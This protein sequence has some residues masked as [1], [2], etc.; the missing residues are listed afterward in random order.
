[1]KAYLKSKSE[2]PCI[3]IY[4]H[5]Y[6]PDVAS[7][8][9][10]LKEL[11]EGMISEFRIVV[12][13]V[14]PSYGGTVNDEYKKQK[15]YFEKINGVEVI[16]VR[17]PKFDKTKKISRIKNILAYFLRAMKVTGKIKN[18]EY[19]YSISQP[20]VLGG[21]LGVWG[22][23]RKRASFL[24]N[25]QD[26]NPEQIVATGY[27]KNKIILSLMMYFDKFSCQKAD[28]VIVVGRDM[29][30]TLR[31]RFTDK[32]GNISRKIPK[33][34]FIN[35]WVDEKEIYPLDLYNERVMEFRIKYGLENKFVIMY[36]GNIG[37]YYDLENLIKI[38]KDFRKGY[39]K[40]GKYE[41]GKK[42]RDGREVVFAFVGAGSIKDKL[43]DYAKSHRF[44]N[45]IFIPYQ[46]KENLI[47][48]LNAADVH[49]CVSAEGIKG[50]S[51][52]SKLY[53]IMATGKPVL[54]VMEEGAEARLIVEETQCGL[55]C[56]PGDYE[57][58]KENIQWFID[59]AGI[60]SVLAMG[61]SGREYLVKN[62]TKD[63]SVKKYIEEI[64]LIK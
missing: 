39:T 63:V 19:V 18:V 32:K 40:S 9:Q 34:A 59:N 36:S 16:R 45:I 5:Y 56:N 20:P 15:Y 24:Y 13:C 23:I 51:V 26:Y 35:N 3:L 11:A 58:I 43:V 1:M 27:S 8:G 28:K 10:I 49:W 12:I 50:V 54:G 33:Y 53:G 41:D 38:I 6:F 64:K 61:K 57:Q 48:S 29:V 30:D 44:E 22:K 55:V 37:L 52:P 17:V 25:I 2:K 62:L 7:T 42:A 47:Y 4:G 14:V 21:L 31:R 60:E 46:D